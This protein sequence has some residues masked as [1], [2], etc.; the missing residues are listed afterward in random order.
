MSETY[1]SLVQVQEPSRDLFS[2]LSDSYERARPGYASDA[3]AW[4]AREL[5]IG[6]GS[7][8][9]DVG[10]GTGKLTR[11]LV[12]LQADVIAVEPQPDMRTQFSAGLPAITVIDA[13][14]ET[15]PFEPASLDAV[16]V[17]T[18]FHWF[19]AAR[20]LADSPVCF[21]QEEA[22]R[23]SSTTRMRQSH[24]GL[25]SMKSRRSRSLCDCELFDSRLKTRLAAFR[26][27]QTRSRPRTASV[28]SKRGRFRST[29]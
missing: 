28:A 24:S 19:D 14:A 9:A 7:R 3:L 2:G 12:E 11:Q 5:R 25:H 20:A 29:M 17:G 26:R 13:V 27:A 21:G 22:S 16:M 18:A 10:A 8:I 4:V 6:A 15:L 23:F 1:C